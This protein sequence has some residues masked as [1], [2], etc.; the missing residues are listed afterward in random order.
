[1][2]YPCDSIA[3]LPL[4]PN[5]GFAQALAQQFAIDDLD[6]LVINRVYSNGEY[7]PTISNELSKES[8]NDAVARD[9]STL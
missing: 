3:F 5:D 9:P 1:M 4:R 7:C 6:K 8:L 2:T